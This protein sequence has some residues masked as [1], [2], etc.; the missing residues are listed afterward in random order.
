MNLPLEVKALGWAVLVALLS[1]GG[2]LLAALP[3]KTM[4]SGSSTAAASAEASSEIVATPEL[5]AQGHEFF[6]TSCSECHGDDATGD[7]GPD[8]H[9]LAISNARIATTIKNGVKGEM[10]TFA[11]KY[12]DQQIATLVIY[13]R[14]LR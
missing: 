4:M 1:L 6:A 14:S 3:I 9:N 8:L 5:V 11:K 13:L 2:A 12:N 7:E 10:P